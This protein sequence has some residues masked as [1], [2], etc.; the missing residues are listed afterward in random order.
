MVIS[1]DEAIQV[2]YQV[3]NSGIISEDI[4]EELQDI[5]NCIEGEKKG[6]FLWG[7]D[8]DHIDLFTARREDLIDDAWEQHLDELWEKYRIKEGD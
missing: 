3:M 8:D 4:E 2:L 5:A 1:R 7:A 6:L